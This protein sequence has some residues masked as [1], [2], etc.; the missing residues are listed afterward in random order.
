M[1]SDSSTDII[2]QL[3]E[4]HK[5]LMAFI[6]L[7]EVSVRATAD[8]SF[9]KT[10][11]VS[12]A[13]YF[14]TRMTESVLDV[15]SEATN[16]A[17]P[18]VEFVRNKAVERRYHDWFDWTRRNA[19]RFI[20]AFGNDFKEYMDGWVKTHQ[21]SIRAFMEIG[22][23]RNQLVH[24]NFGLIPLDKTVGEIV[25]MY[26]KALGF[27]DEFPDELRNYLQRSKA[28]LAE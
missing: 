16:N 15:F 2:E 6:P 14:E 17:Q 28:A 11:M 8:A 13:S 5:T 22:S 3:V 10:L 23:F 19:N 27:V 9:A 21:K 1:A 4:E 12:A 26:Q 25:D 24:K 18:L 7:Q 20:E